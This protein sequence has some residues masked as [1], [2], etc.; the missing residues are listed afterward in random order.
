MQAFYEPFEVIYIHAF[1]G[2]YV[3][4]SLAVL[5]FAWEP[6]ERELHHFGY[7]QGPLDSKRKG[8]SS[9]PPFKSLVEVQHIDPGSNTCFIYTVRD[10][11]CVMTKIS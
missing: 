2:S 6:S 1:M 4:L 10:A 3:G 5:R 9:S 11:K 7:V 8:L